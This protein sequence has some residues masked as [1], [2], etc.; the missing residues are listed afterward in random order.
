MNT[1][2]RLLSVFALVFGFA[3]QAAAEEESQNY[4]VAAGTVV[5]PAGLTAKEVQR[6]I[7]EAGAAEDF[8]VKAR[9]DEKVVLYRVDGKWTSLLTCTYTTETIQIYSKSV[10]GGEQKLPERW[11]KRLRR[12]ISERLN[13]VAIMK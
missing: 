3:F 2:L 12:T 1:V 11:I 7:M 9:D 10:R 6:G 4:G 13:T 5:V 8:I